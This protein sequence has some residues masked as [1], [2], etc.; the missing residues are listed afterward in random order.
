[1]P[2]RS[3]TERMCLPLSA[4]SLR[5]K[6]FA[7]SSVRF[8]ASA[9]LTSGSGVPARTPSPMLERAISTRRAILPCLMR[10]SVASA[11]RIDTSNASPP[12]MRST[13][14]RDGVWTIVTL[15]GELRSNCA[16]RSTIVVF[17]GAGHI[18]LMSAASRLRRQRE[19]HRQNAMRRA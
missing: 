16:T 18:S 13:I 19:C 4:P 14:I 11:V 8:T 10:A 7:A 9:E 2:S 3:N 5:A 1:M 12:W 6:D 15:C 17:I